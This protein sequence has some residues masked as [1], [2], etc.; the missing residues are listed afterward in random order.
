M[1]TLGRFLLALV[2]LV[3]A[4]AGLSLA[5]LV[6][7][8]PN[9]YKPEIETA[10]GR[11]LGR[12]LKLAGPIEISW[13][14]DIRLRANALSLGNAPGFSAPVMVGVRELELAVETLPLLRGRLTLETV[15]IHGLEVNLARDARGLTNWDS[16]LHASH[17]QG[18]SDP[19]RLGALAL[20]GVD[21]TD[22][23]L[24]WQDDRNHD[25]LRL[26]RFK[27]HTGP[28]AFDQPVDFTLSTGIESTAPAVV[29][30]GSASGRLTFEARAGRYQ[31]QDF[32]STVTLAGKAL[33]GGT[34]T[35]S[36]ATALDLD[37]RAGTARLSA[38]KG[39]GLGL[40]L[41]GDLVV[42]HLLGPRQGGKAELALE[43]KDLAVLFKAFDLPARN[44]L[45]AMK[46]RSLDVHGTFSV[47]VGQDRVTVSNFVAKLPG[48]SLEG[49]LAASQ[50]GSAMPMLRARVEGKIPD[51]PAVV[52]FA[53]EWMGG[54]AAQV[55]G[56]LLNRSGSREMNLKLDLDT[57]VAV[58]RV[59]MPSLH[60]TLL[61]STLD[62]EI[63]PLGGSA[64]RPAFTGNLVATSPNLPLLLAVGEAIRG[65]SAGRIEQ[66]AALAGESPPALRASAKLDADL[67][68]DRCELPFELD[69]LGN[70]LKAGLQVGGLK[71]RMPVLRGQLDGSGPDLPKLLAQFDALL[72][73]APR[74]AGALAEADKSFT[75]ATGF[76][77][78][79]AKATLHLTDFRASSLGLLAQGELHAVN[80]R[81]GDG[82]LDGKLKLEAPQPARLLQWLAL[83]DL[84]PHLQDF[85]LDTRLTGSPSALIL[86]PVNASAN[87]QGKARAALALDTG[88]VEIYPERELLQVKELNLHGPG[89]EAGATL[90]VS[91]W[92]TA[93]TWRGQFT[94]PS[95]DLRSVLEGF[96]VALPTMA[97][98]QTLRAVSVDMI[99]TGGPGRFGFERI[100]AAVDATH[101]NG[102]FSVDSFIGP[103]LA[104]DLKVDELNLDRYLPP[105]A[106]A[107]GGAVA[108]P[109]AAAAGA[110]TLPR[111]LL[112][113]LKLAGK[114]H[115]DTLQVSGLKL[116]D[117][118]LG[119][120]GGG[121]RLTLEPVNAEGYQGRYSGVATL[122]ATGKVPQL[123]LN[124][125]LAKVSLEPLLQDLNGH[126]EL[127]GG[128]NFEARLTASGA[129]PAALRESLAGQATFAIRNGE[130][131][132]V[133]AT[134]LL[135]AA[136]QLMLGKGKPRN[137]IG[138]KTSFKALTGTLEI[139]DGAVFNRD[140]RLDGNG[141]RMTGEGTLYKLRDHTLDYAV[142]LVVDAST[143]DA[144]GARYK[145][146]TLEIPL[147]CRGPLTPASCLPDAKSLLKSAT[148]KQV[149]GALKEALEGKA[150]RQ[151][152]KLLE[153]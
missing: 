132:G 42:D 107:Q 39:E 61:D 71:D 94:L 40:K 105:Q 23:T 66:L 51:L 124:A 29:G 79:P 150:G 25:T 88:A 38:L 28:L 21:I 126:R 78:D 33:P 41:A 60:V 141:F 90:D 69:L 14:P 98:A 146:P 152:K 116:K 138:G 134:G 80:T 62:A 111:E 58:A 50:L 54:D 130:L 93:P 96:D 83:P 142:R 136:E 67:A 112:R 82:T 97:D 122:D 27:V 128:M 76:M 149:K 119:A 26:S 11:Q 5:V 114:L 103:E 48:A 16:L 8:D 99:F 127:A 55:L 86:G 49:E 44:R 6:N 47:D 123:T 77:A 100:H 89:L 7:L 125:S 135:R 68:T 115:L 31:L 101:V 36:L 151:L 65:G 84:A 20:G 145:F 140:L 148:R 117:V 32:A 133:D 85:T 46:N 3:L 81:R 108:A 74:D 63:K 4:A 131:R 24:S 147:H 92:R 75:F 18:E 64:G 95:T 37:L 121:G 43:A 113:A 70:Q 19:R 109:G 57:D 45:L 2:L 10:V 34:A 143:A 102:E 53:N 91:A 106:T 73:R 129:T 137:P 15:R 56:R 110:A 118:N 13:W 1:Y 17:A 12:E 144:A 139:R 59:A 35:L 52:L 22:A 9:H 30:N 104:F 120:S 72:S 87:W 153:R